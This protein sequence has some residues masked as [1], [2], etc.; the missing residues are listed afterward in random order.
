MGNHETKTVMRKIPQS[1]RI[2]AYTAE[3]SMLSAQDESLTYLGEKASYYMN[4][5]M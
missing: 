4:S 5:C 1:E 3:Q 2:S